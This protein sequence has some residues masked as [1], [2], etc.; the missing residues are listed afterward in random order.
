MCVIIYYKGNVSSHSNNNLLITDQTILKNQIYR[1][2]IL[3]G[4]NKYLHW[5]SKVCVFSVYVLTPFSLSKLLSL[6]LAKIFTDLAKIYMKRMS[7]SNDQ[8]Q[9]GRH[10][11]YRHPDK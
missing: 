1:F 10:T 8:P 5:E 6:F 2:H 3:I 7:S 11:S 9:A 4:L